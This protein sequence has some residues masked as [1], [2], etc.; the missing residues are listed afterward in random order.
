MPPS[1]VV[2]K[3]RCPVALDIS[4]AFCI[5]ITTIFNQGVSF[6]Q[7]IHTIANGLVG[8]ETCKALQDDRHLQQAAI[9]VAGLIALRNLNCTWS[10]PSGTIAKRTPNCMFEQT[11]C[12]AGW[13][14]V[15]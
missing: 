6:C 12:L 2:H 14:G 1:L 8:F 4:K 7:N 3:I 10:E 9:L 13:C 5:H 11:S 15:G